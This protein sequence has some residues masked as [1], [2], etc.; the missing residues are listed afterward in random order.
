MGRKI[1]ED[2][3][4]AKKFYEQA[5]NLQAAGH[6]DRAAYFYRRSIEFH[7]TPK[8]HTFL[9]FVYSL[10]GLLEDAINECQQ[11]IE[12]DPRL[13]NPYNDIGAYLIRLGKYNEAAPW[14]FKALQA[15]DYE[16]YCYPNL[17]LGHI[18]E[19]KGR[20]DK[21]LYYFQAAVKENPQYKPARTALDRLSGKLN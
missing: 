13:G 1:K 6:I 4:T 7:P 19:K 9:G 3:A 5:Y 11:A 14:L 20:W 17:N 8:A 10:K 18:Y 21:A 12:L 15:P 16:N 2:P